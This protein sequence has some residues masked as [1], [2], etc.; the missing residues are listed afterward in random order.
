MP[1]GLVLGAL[2]GVTITVPAPA[3][4]FGNAG[5]VARYSVS[6]GITSKSPVLKPSSSN[7]LVITSGAVVTPAGTADVGGGAATGVFFIKAH[8]VNAHTQAMAARAEVAFIIGAARA[9]SSV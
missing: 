3:S 9:S 5:L 2:G 6:L 8:P 4:A 7:G 1:V